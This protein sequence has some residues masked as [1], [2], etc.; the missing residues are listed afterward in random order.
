[1]G[2][3]TLFMDHKWIHRFLFFNM[4]IQFISRPTIWNRMQETSCI[5]MQ[6]YIIQAFFLFFKVLFNSFKTISGLFMKEN[7]DITLQF[8]CFSSIYGPIPVSMQCL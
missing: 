5:D 7:S 6:V 3:I 8:S 1:M 4:H 2:H